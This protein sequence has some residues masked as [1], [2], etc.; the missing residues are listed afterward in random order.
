MNGMDDID[1][2]PLDS[3][4]L[5]KLE[6]LLNNND[7]RLIRILNQRGYRINYTPEN[8]Y[9]Y[10]EIGDVDNLRLALAFEDNSTNWFRKTREDGGNNWVAL[11]R[12]AQN[13]WYECC[14]LLLSNGA[15]INIQDFYNETP[16][17]LAARHGHLSIVL[18][19]IEQGCDINM[20]CWGDETVVNYYDFNWS[21]K[22][23]SQ[24][25]FFNHK[26]I[27][28][29]LYDKGSE[30]IEDA[31]LAAARN[32]SLDCINFLLDV[33]LDMNKS[34]EDDCYPIVQACLSR[35]TDGIKQ[36]IL[37]GADVNIM[38][39]SR[40]SPLMYAAKKVL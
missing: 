18:L 6:K 32:S 26:D 36:F 39:N 8:V 30:G 5:D 17:H 28:A 20:L 10:A 31:L 21:G 37:R 38:D 29:V 16:L 11:H 27:V 15:D 7:Q 35:Y 34:Y 23:I 33:G 2:D 13:G 22:A 1:D 40:M 3:Y 12:A 19:L 24:A 4:F 9:E 25:A 14:Q